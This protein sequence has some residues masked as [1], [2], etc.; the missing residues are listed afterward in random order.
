VRITRSAE[1]TP[2]EHLAIQRVSALHPELR[3]AVELFDG[4]AHLI[5]ARLEV[6][7]A[8]QRTRFERWLARAVDSGPPELQAFVTKLRQD[9]KAVV[10]ALVLPHSQGQT[11]GRVN[12]LKA[13]KRAMFGRAGFDLLRRR[14]LYTAA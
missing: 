12:R 13:L 1:R 14:V 4:F 10:A 7:T 5:R 8:R 6:P 3:C 9:L 11:E 2:E